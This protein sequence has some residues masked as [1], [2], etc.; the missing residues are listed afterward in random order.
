LDHAVRC[1]AGVCE[2]EVAVAEQARKVRLMCD[3][4]VG[5][6]QPRSSP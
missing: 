4:T 2:P 1:C 5:M 6:P 3:A